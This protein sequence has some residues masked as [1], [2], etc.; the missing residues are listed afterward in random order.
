[1]SH[2]P[3]AEETRAVAM[4]G[5]EGDPLKGKVVVEDQKLAHGEPRNPSDLRAP[6]GN[7]HKRFPTLEVCLIDQPTPITMPN[8]M[9]RQ[10]HR[11]MA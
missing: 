5:S 10:T 8:Q 2:H 9:L 7:S 3:E 4:M 1:M 11:I 6:V